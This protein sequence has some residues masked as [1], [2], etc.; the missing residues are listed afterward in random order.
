MLPVAYQYWMSC[1]SLQLAVARP[2]SWLRPVLQLA[3]LQLMAASE[4][5]GMA[6]CCDRNEHQPHL[7]SVFKSPAS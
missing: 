4:T 2:A 3:V 6:W 1:R 5:T 7:Q